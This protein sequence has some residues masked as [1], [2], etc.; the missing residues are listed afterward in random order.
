MATK[1]WLL[2]GIGLQ[3]SDFQE[4]EGPDARENVASI[5]YTVMSELDTGAKLLSISGDNANNNPAKAE[6]IF[7]IL[8]A[9]FDTEIFPSACYEIPRRGKL[10]SLSRPPIY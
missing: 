2:L 9:D 6:I 7:G 4:V 5:I 10:C 8:K 3:T 1:S